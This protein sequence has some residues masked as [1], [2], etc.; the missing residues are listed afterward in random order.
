MSQRPASAST[1]PGLPPPLCGAVAPD[2]DEVGLAAV[3]RRLAEGCYR[4]TE[5]LENLAEALGAELSPPP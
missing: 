1:P 4:R 3:R 5:V 2:A